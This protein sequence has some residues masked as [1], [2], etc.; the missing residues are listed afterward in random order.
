MEEIRLEVELK[1]TLDAVEELPVGRS[2][3]ER[4]VSL[5]SRKQVFCEET[6]NSLI[7]VSPGLEDLGILRIGLGERHGEIYSV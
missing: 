7:D 3:E 6:T 4:R 5:A 1:F 2:E